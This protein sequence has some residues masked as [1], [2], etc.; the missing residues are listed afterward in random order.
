MSR[1]SSVLQQDGAAE[2][3]ASV[4]STPSAVGNTGIAG[5]QKEN[6]AEVTGSENIQSDK[7]FSSE[8]NKFVPN[9]PTGDFHANPSSGN[10]A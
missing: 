9:N 6:A 10:I 1:T 7:S 3:G 4:V 8:T 2:A 5:A